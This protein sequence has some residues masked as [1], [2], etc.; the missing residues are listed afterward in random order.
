MYSVFIHHTT[1]LACP[2]KSIIDVKGERFDEF[3]YFFSFLNLIH[4][5]SQ[6]WKTEKCLARNNKTTFR[7]EEIPDDGFNCDSIY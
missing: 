7:S 2:I 3:F 5:I 1:L 4:G 6:S